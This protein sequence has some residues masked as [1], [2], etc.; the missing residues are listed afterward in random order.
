M[1]AGGGM[2]T[3]AAGFARLFGEGTVSGLDDGQLLERF[4][5]GRD[6]VAFGC[7]VERHGPMVRSVCRRALRDDHAADDAF[8][9]TF[10]LLVRKARTLRSANALGP[11]LHR[12]ALRV[13]IRAERS[14]TKRRAKEFASPEILNRAASPEAA[15]GDLSRLLHEAVDSLPEKY[16]API[17]MCY[18]EGRTHDEAAMTLRWPIG[19][20]KGRLSRGREVL[21]ARLARRGVVAPAALILAAMA[22]E[23]GA[24]VPSI[25]LE[26]TVQAAIGFA[27]GGTTATLA[28]GMSSGAAAVLAEEAAR[29]MTIKRC[30]TIAASLVT[31]LGLIG[32]GAGVLARQEGGKPGAAKHDEP[33]AAEAK[34]PNEP[35]TDLDRLQGRWARTATEWGGQKLNE[36]ARPEVFQEIVIRNDQFFGTRDDGKLGAS[37]TLTLDGSKS[38]KQFEWHRAGVTGEEITQGIY[39]IDGEDDFALSYDME[40]PRKIPNGFDMPNPGFKLTGHVTMKFHRVRS[41]PE[42]SVEEKAELAKLQGE[43]QYVGGERNGESFVPVRAHGTNSGMQLVFQGAKHYLRQNDVGNSEIVPESVRDVSLDLTRTPPVMELRLSRA[44]AR[45]LKREPR[46]DRSNYKLSGD[47]LILCSNGPSATN[48]IATADVPP[49]ELVT[50]PGDGRILI[51]YERVVSPTGDLKRL[52]GTWEVSSV[53]V[54]GVNHPL[55]VSFAIDDIKCSWMNGGGGIAFQSVITLDESRK[56]PVLTTTP[57]PPDWMGAA[58]MIYHIRGDTLTLCGKDSGPQ[59]GLPTTFSAEKREDQWLI[60]AKRKTAPVLAPAGALP[61]NVQVADERKVEASKPSEAPANAVAAEPKKADERTGAEVA[62]KLSYGADQLDEERMGMLSRADD[63]QMEIELLRDVIR[64]LLKLILAIEHSVQN[65]TA[66]DP[67]VQAENKKFAEERLAKLRDNLILTR[68][69]L[70]KLRLAGHQLQTKADH[71]AAEI[72]AIRAKAEA[73][74]ERPGKPNTAQVGDMISVEVLEALPGR[75]ISGERPVRADGTISLGVYG[76]LPVAGLTRPEIKVKVVEHMLKFLTDAALGVAAE[77]EKGQA[78]RVP[79]AES[80]RVA[81]DI[82]P[83]PPR[84]SAAADDDLDRR[85]EK[86]IA[87]YETRRRFADVEGRP[88]LRRPVINRP[89]TR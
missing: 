84:R 52:Q 54:R 66:L 32:G 15:D 10:L 24:S 87:N 49:G 89:K 37:R 13:A 85:I 46:V 6:A 64:E 29:A 56:P 42:P 22:T 62:A 40:N 74:A 43:W 19:S 21:K 57:P 47:R 77:D 11:W 69:D 71:A 26:K 4:L 50:R 83:S 25:L 59:N 86:A 55:R 48:R 65:P 73:A 14:A 80:D 67:N 38:P 78:V 76:D 68:R 58:T 41:L 18:L 2:G 88:N 23:A 61:S 60:V 53:R 17:V 36:P 20:V 81:V 79:P 35:K 31:M 82:I 72:Q 3:V 9:A 30:A 45:R 51:I 70:T 34:K 27:A 44:E 5:T 75:P 28:A 39:R 7:L 1:M 63:I 12:V 33:R 16:R 8:Q